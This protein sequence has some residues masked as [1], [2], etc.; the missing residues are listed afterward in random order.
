MTTVLPESQE[1]V[2]LIHSR[3]YGLNTLGAFFGTLVAGLYLIPKFGYE[4]SLLGLGALNIFV[5]LFYIKNKLSG[6]SYEKQEPEVLS[7]PFNE[8][9]LYAL[10]FVAGLTSLS[11][12]VLWFRI[13]GLSIG[14]SFV[15]FPF[16]LS[17]FVLMIGLGSLTLKKIQVRNFQNVLAG[18]LIFSS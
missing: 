10:G 12:E 4:I 8:K 3:I 2:N 9:F 14:N 11:L 1:N 13:L 7:H 16:V 6:S 5:S 18:S 15:I 17:I